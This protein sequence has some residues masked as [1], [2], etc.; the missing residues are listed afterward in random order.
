MSF[1]GGGNFWWDDAL[2]GKVTEIYEMT[3]GQVYKFYAFSDTSDPY[4]I[5][6]TRAGQSNPDPEPK[7]W[8]G[9]PNFVQLLLRY[10]CFGWLWMN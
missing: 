10:I 1:S 5:T 2:G 9:L 7:W 6:I 3:A 4:T 8:E